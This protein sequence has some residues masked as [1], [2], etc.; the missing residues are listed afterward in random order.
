MRHLEAMPDHIETVLGTSDQ[1]YGLAADHA[2]TRSVLFLG[3]HAGYPVALEGALN[4]P[5]N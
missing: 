3:R 2:T 4:R 5:T 1:V